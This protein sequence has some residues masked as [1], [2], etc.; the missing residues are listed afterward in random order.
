MPAA[1]L[2]HPAPLPLLAAPSPSKCTESLL[3]AVH[4][5]AL[6]YTAHVPAATL[7]HPASH[8]LLATPPV[9]KCQRRKLL[10]CTQSR[11]GTLCTCRYRRW[12]IPP[13]SRCSVRVDMLSDARFRSAREGVGARCVRAGGNARAFRLAAVARDAVLVEVHRVAAYCR[14]PVGVA[15]RCARGGGN[16]GASRLAAV[17]R[18]AVRVEVLSVAAYC[19]A[20]GGVGTLRTCIAWQ[21]LL[22]T[23][24][25]STLLASQLPCARAGSPARASRLAAVA[26]GAVRVETLSDAV[27]RSARKASGHVVYS[28]AARGS[29]RERSAAAP[30]GEQRERK[31]PPCGGPPVTL[32]GGTGWRAP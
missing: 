28:V 17:A 25:V 6:E 23:P 21:L 24:S 20:R 22:A 16:A 9:L 26:R 1:T 5:E 2:G 8:L 10:I 3:I 12:G 31:E 29:V 4:A 30:G 32:G 19:R 14:A 7:G 11:R 27:F 18:D 15:A 13:L